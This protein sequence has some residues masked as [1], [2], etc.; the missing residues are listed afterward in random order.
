VTNKKV[1]LLVAVLVLL[2]GCQSLSDRVANLTR[3]ER[4]ADA[5]TLLDKYEA[6]QKGRTGDDL[7]YAKAVFTQK[8]EAHYTTLYRDAIE[9]GRPLSARDV[10]RDAYQLCPWSAAL[11]EQRT[12]AED[13]VRRISE[14]EYKWTSSKDLSVQEARRMLDETA[15]FARL[16]ADFPALRDSRSDARLTIVTWCSR[17]LLDRG[18]DLSS[19]E[20]AVLRDHL[21]AV[22]PDLTQRAPL[23]STIDVILGLPSYARDDAIAPS[24]GL[25]TVVRL[26]SD[27]LSSSSWTASTAPLYHALRTLLQ[28]WCQRDLARYLQTA[29][30]ADDVLELGEA[31]FDGLREL[32]SDPDLRTGLS[33]A[34][35]QRAYKL[36]TGGPATPV[37]LVH[38][39]R[40]ETIAVSST[41]D[42]IAQAETKCRALLAMAEPAPLTY[43]I[44]VGPAV[45]PPLQAFLVRAITSEIVARMDTNRPARMASDGKADIS[46]TIE[47]AGLHLPDYRSLPS[48]TSSYFS[49]YESVPN[50]AKTALKF[51]LDMAES[52]VQRA[53]WNYNSAVSSHNIYPTPYS[54]QNVNTAYNTYKMGVD[55]YNNLV[56][57][58]NLTPS[59]VQREVYLP[60]TFQEGYLL[61]GWTLAIRL[62]VAGSEVVTQAESVDRDFVR[63][64]ARSTDARP[65]YRRDYQFSHAISFEALM[66]HLNSVISTVLR[67]AN[68]MLLNVEYETR[69]SL[70]QEESRCLSWIDHPWG[71]QPA[72]LGGLGLPKWMTTAAAQV[73]MQ[74]VPSTLPRIVVSKAGGTRLVKSSP[75]DAA[76]A[77]GDYVCRIVSYDKD[78]EVGSGSGTLVGENG[79]VLTAA[80]VLLA[81]SLRVEFAAG[82]YSGAYDADVLIEN[83]HRDV[84]LIRLKGLG[85]RNYAALRLV[86]PPVKGEAILAIGN[87]SIASGGT[88]VGGVTTGIVSNP[89]VDAFG[90]PQ[91]VA[92]ITVASGSSGGP[93]FSLDTGEVL[94][95]VLAVMQ[96]GINLGGVSSSGYYCIAAPS[97][98]LGLWLGLAWK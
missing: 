77:L 34:H 12:T 51:Q 13:L 63:T 6:R 66:G 53:K 33:L 5:R 64:G 68:E 28:S 8:V 10:A 3:S 27:P 44:S 47:Q 88:N 46:L 17:Q 70:T 41:I 18:F 37:A 69:Q 31:V 30:M 45:D 35:I 36:M 59:T 24:D 39:R 21:S 14:L 61:F 22:V 48:V 90:Q 92:D 4:F 60:Y 15:P 54:L 67:D 82:R 84:A 16:L 73:T 95:V 74:P 1:A 25:S 58:Y 65:E 93:L 97:Q 79:L 23:L 87:P 32:Q 78:G 49:H 40:A 7:V 91:L 9:A 71:V 56:N 43:R 57:L 81:S 85:N 72:L 86:E 19:D 89:K 20:A 96:P 52:S 94:G 80:H 42:Q 62:D 29:A 50:P 38:L 2:A 98:E 55:H 11:S 75:R 76:S 83:R 26:F